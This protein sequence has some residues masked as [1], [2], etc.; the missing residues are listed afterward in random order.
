M[1]SDSQNETLWISLHD[2]NIVDTSNVTALMCGLVVLVYFC[3]FLYQNSKPSY[4]PEAGM[5]STDVTAQPGE[6]WLEFLSFYVDFKL[7]FE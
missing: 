6:R 4:Q 1:N 3:A 2:S 5:L 7:K